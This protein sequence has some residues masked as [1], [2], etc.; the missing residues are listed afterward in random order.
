MM[1]GGGGDEGAGKGAGGD[2]FYTARIVALIENGG[3]RRPTAAV[4]PRPRN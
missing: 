2:D 1:C 4:R 3:Q